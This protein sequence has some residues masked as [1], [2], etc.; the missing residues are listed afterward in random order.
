MPGPLATLGW[1]FPLKH[2]MHAVD[3]AM[4]TGSVALGHL[5]FV[6]LWAVAGT[7]V[8]LRWFRWAPS[9]RGAR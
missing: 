8:A 9:E 4:A 3:G 5:A 2:L 1:I 7:V 6:A